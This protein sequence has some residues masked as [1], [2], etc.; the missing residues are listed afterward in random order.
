MVRVDD[1]RRPAEVGDGVRDAHALAEGQDTDFALE[2]VD[3]KLEEDIA[4]NLVFYM[5][6]VNEEEAR[7]DVGS[8]INLFVTPSSNPFDFSHS[9]TCSTLHSEGCTFGLGFSCRNDDPLGVRTAVATD[10]KGTVAG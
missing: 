1:G 9:T 8:P 2:E 10:C 5:R 7:Y 3:V 4:G 6:K